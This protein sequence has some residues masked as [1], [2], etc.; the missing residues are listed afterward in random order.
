MNPNQHTMAS[1]YQSENS[2]T[3][4]SRA[5]MTTCRFHRDLENLDSPAPYV[6]NA[7]LNVQLSI[8]AVFLNALSFCAIRQIRK[9]HLPSKLLL[10]SLVLT[11][12][13]IGVVVQPLF[14]AFLFSKLE[15][16]I[17]VQC[18]LLSTFLVASNIFG[19]TSVVLMTAI[20]IDRYAA[21]NLY[22]RY[23]QI[24]SAKRIR[25][26][27]VLAWFPGLAAALAGL[28][29][30]PL[31]VGLIIAAVSTSFVVT[32]FAYFKIYQNLRLFSRQREGTRAHGQG[33]DLSKFRRVTAGMIRLKVLFV[34]CFLP[35]SCT[36]LYSHF[37]RFT[38]ANQCILEFSATIVHLNACLNPLTYALHVPGVR[39]YFIQKLR[40]PRS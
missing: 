22:T 16:T 40:N 24:V 5:A 38:A 32:F 13:G 19:C 7:V 2:T 6:V 25:L 1:T 15:S 31:Q 17:D 11:D 28:Y 20:S 8:A 4:A 21:L 30:V 34:L 23:R 12:L 39:G 3:G 37:T 35:C 14:V 26:L 29:S 33:F 18:S 36:L 27:V 9:L 10:C